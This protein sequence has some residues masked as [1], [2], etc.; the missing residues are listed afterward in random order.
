MSEHEWAIGG[1]EGTTGQYREGVRRPH[2]SIELPCHA[3]E[4][5]RIMK[6]D[7]FHLCPAEGALAGIR[8]RLLWTW[9]E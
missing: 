9:I 8:I 3:V 7:L 6:S 5:T 4:G 1:T 2:K